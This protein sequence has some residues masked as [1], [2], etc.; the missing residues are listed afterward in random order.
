V[1]FTVRPVQ[2]LSACTTVHFTVRF[3]QSLSACTTVHFTLYAIVNRVQFS[4]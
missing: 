2:S 4:L 3:V 1:H